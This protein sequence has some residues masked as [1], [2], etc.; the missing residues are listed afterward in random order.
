MTGWQ[1][2]NFAVLMAC[3]AATSLF[4]AGFWEGKSRQIRNMLVAGQHDSMQTLESSLNDLVDR[5]LVTYEQARPA[6][7]HELAVCHDPA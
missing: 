7:P 6:T 2:P 4:A 3:E 1:K 5:G